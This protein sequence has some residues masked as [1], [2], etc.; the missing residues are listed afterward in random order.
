MLFVSL[1]LFLLTWPASNQSA[2]GTD[3]APSS[4]LVD[5]STLSP[6]FAQELYSLPTVQYVVNG[7]KV[8]CFL[9]S[10]VAHDLLQKI[11]EANTH[12]G[13]K[14]TPIL[15]EVLTLFSFSFYFNFQSF[16]TTR[17]R[18][19]ESSFLN[20]YIHFVVAICPI[21]DPSAELIH[22]EEVAEEEEGERDVHAGDTQQRLDVLEDE[23][24]GNIHFLLL[25]LF[26]SFFLFISPHLHWVIRLWL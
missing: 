2:G 3:H 1:F 11:T 18:P 6:E 25:F 13:N 15:P 16:F 24:H 26:F 8:T 23:Q 12:S 7:E 10:D 19:I 20:F 17:L 22:D 9:P 5:T 4:Q 14:L 21:P